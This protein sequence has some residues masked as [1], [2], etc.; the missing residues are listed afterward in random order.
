MTDELRNSTDR[1]PSTLH[2]GRRQ[3]KTAGSQFLLLFALAI[4]LVFLQAASQER[5]CEPIFAVVGAIQDP[6]RLAGA[7][8]IQLQGNFA[9][10]TGKWNSFAIVDISDPSTP[11]VTGSLMAGVG[12][13]GA[14][15]V[16][17][18]VCLLGA[19]EL[20]VI[21]ISSPVNPSITKRI[22]HKTIHGINGMARWGTHVLTASKIGYVN[23]FD[24][25]EP[26]NPIFLGSL[27]TK[28]NGGIEAP[29]D[30]AVLGDH[31]VIVN[32][33][34]GAPIKL[35][36]YR[37]GEAATG[38]LWPIDEWIV[39]GALRESVMDGANRIVVRGRH[40][41]V[42]SNYAHTVGMIDLS[43]PRRPLLA[44]VLETSDI[45]PSGLTIDGS[46]LFA[47]C[48]RTVE[49]I[50]IRDPQH[51]RPL[52][53]V[54]APD[55]LLIGDPTTYER[56]RRRGGGHDLEYRNGLLYVTGQS[57]NGLG[58]LEFRSNR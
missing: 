12:D 11:R 58:I 27:D 21:D 40:A 16:M 30:I 43:D 20:L 37:V 8:D 28:R 45:Q 6:D 7:H 22:S 15:M 49:A 39:E 13:G 51:P 44:A 25:T 47:A 50:D 54:K 34:L 2:N 18:D 5:E 26:S 36:I 46:V 23:V 9:Y 33:E 42:A 55:L 57:S 10:I 14:L 48:E 35:R 56:Q 3:G 24:A 4:T 38:T 53:H 19:D 31:M 29:H 1:S 41:A 17:D 32:Q 52:G